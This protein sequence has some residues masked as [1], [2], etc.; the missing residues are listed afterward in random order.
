MTPLK[1]VLKSTLY[2]ILIWIGIG[3]IVVTG[4]LLFDKHEKQS[5]NYRMKAFNIS[6]DNSI[7]YFVEKLTDSLNFSLDS[8]IV[9]EK[10]RFY[11]TM[12]G[13][14]L[15][16]KEHSVQQE[17]TI[18][19]T[20]KTNKVFLISYYFKPI[21]RVTKDGLIEIFYFSNERITQSFGHRPQLAS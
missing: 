16:T 17:L 7:E 1:D 6:M 9:F 5:D 12:H 21:D 15:S 10:D 19:A 13:P 8:A 18:S 3:V 4:M 14:V 2:G 20:P 11:A